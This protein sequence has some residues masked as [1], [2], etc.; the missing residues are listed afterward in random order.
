MQLLRD[1]PEKLYIG[2]NQDNEKIFLTRPNWDFD[3]Y[4]GF[5]YIGNKDLHTHL[6]ILGN[7]NLFDNIKH[8]FQSFILTDKE[9]WVFCELVQTIYHLRT[10]AEVYHRGGSHYTQ[11][12]CQKDLLNPE[13]YQHIN[14]VLIPKLIDEMYKVLKV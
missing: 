3:W 4:W 5:G 9:L 10:L 1:Y 6:N 14:A 7:L 11:N 12:P 2:K 8:Y 13:Q